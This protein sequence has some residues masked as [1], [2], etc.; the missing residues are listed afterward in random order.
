MLKPENTL[1][2]AQWRFVI[3][4]SLCLAFFAAVVAINPSTRGANPGAE[5]LTD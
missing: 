3:I 4:G 2:I 5:R 1:R